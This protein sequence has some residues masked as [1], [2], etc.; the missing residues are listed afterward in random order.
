M[1]SYLV[2]WLV[3]MATFGFHVW[4]PYAHAEHPTSIAAIIATIVGL[5]SYVMARLL[6]GELFASFQIFS[7]PLMILAVSHNDLR[8][9]SYHGTG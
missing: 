3:K 9:L 6:F 5:G 8:C 4:L 7:I 1:S 2:G